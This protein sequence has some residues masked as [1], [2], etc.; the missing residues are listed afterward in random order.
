LPEAEPRLVRR[1]HQL[2]MSHLSP[3]D[4]LAA[5]AGS[6]PGA[7]GAF[8]VTQA[9]WRFYDNDAVT[10]AQLVQPLIA[11]V[12]QAA[13]ATCVGH[14]LVACDWSFLSYTQHHAKADRTE[15]ATDASDSNSP[16]G[17][18]LFSA[19]ALS[20]TGGQP[21]GP[22]A[23]QMRFAGGVT[24]TFGPARQE[25]FFRLDRLVPAL[26]HI[27]GLKLGAK[28][29]VFIIDR[30]ADSVGHYRQWSHDGHRFLVRAKTTRKVLHEGCEK[31][32]SQVLA[33]LHGQHAFVPAGEVEIKGRPAL[34]Q[35]AE[36]EVTLHRPARQHRV[37]GRG[38]QRKSKH[39][40]V[41]GPPLPLR[42][43]VSEVRDGAGKLLA[44]WLLLTNLAGTV[45]KTV[46]ARW[47]YWRWRIETYHK[48]LKGAGLQVEQ[49]RQD[50]AEALLKRLLVGSMAVA[51]VWQL[52]RD[53]SPEA[54]ELRNVLVR[55]SGRQMAR[56]TP[57]KPS[58]GF[59][60][61]AL[62]AGLGVLLPMLALLET[63]DAGDLREMV[64]QTLGL[65]LP[66]R[67]SSA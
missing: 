59:T 30:E 7:S 9:A 25:E 57:K 12:D 38:K 21:L 29:P 37:K 10:A 26:R 20:D 67:Q 45:P 3:K 60:E 52:A 13:R 43:V 28:P 18:E 61:P 53:Q 23:M 4:R 6:W 49:W 42:L 5:G 2:V 58:R 15:Y 16:K 1:Y 55:L 19:L 33:A 44:R 40:N 48:L 56:A 46:V 8:A 66:Q 47:Y 27:A 36:T 54:G 32:L 22:V 62:L 50:D 65:P 39:H 11:Q 24:G 31:T 34:A 64:R 35:V 17:Y 14:V 41:S 63:T 51:L